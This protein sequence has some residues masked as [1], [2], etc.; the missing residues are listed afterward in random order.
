MRRPSETL[1]ITEFRPSD[2]SRDRE[3]YDDPHDLGNHLHEV[4]INAEF[5][6]RHSLW[7]AAAAR[8]L[9]EFNRSSVYFDR[10]I[11]SRITVLRGSFRNG[12]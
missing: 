9:R 5:R 12:E 1:A 10:S 8:E 7:C 4:E 11:V 2:S 3:L 6:T